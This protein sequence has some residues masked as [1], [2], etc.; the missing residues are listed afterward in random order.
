MRTRC[1]ER[2]FGAP[3]KSEQGGGENRVKGRIGTAPGRRGHLCRMAWFAH[4]RQPG[5]EELLRAAL[6]HDAPDR[7]AAAAAKLAALASRA[8]GCG[9]KTRCNRPFAACC[10]RA[11]TPVRVPLPF[12]VSP[13]SSIMG[14][15]RT[16]S[17]CWTTS[18]R[19]FAMRPAWPS[20][21]SCRGSSLSWPMISPRSQ[22]GGG[23][24]PAGVGETLQVAGGERQEA[25]GGRQAPGQAEPELSPGD[26]SIFREDPARNSRHFMRRRVIT[27]CRLDLN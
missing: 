22:R 23:G 18:P 7:Q 17:I 24:D 26:S 12:V 3:A 1:C 9:D 2:L 10:A 19:R 5:A 20:R 13:R 14:A 4:S 8:P 11:T 16:C 25:N 15:A 27:T 6:N 21:N